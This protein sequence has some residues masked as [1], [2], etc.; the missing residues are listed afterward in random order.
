MIFVIVNFYKAALGPLPLYGFFVIFNTVP[1]FVRILNNGVFGRDLSRDFNRSFTV[2]G[3][4]FF[5]LFF[6]FLFRF[7]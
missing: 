6:N 4:G 7:K 2:R 5:G 3:R 1:F